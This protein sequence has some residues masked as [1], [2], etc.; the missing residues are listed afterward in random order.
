MKAIAIGQYYPGETPVHRADARLKTTLVIAF[1][2]AIFAIGNF[3]ALVLSA[4]ALALVALNGGLPVRLLVRGLKPLLFIALFALLVNAFLTPGP[5]MAWGFIS[6]SAEGLRIGLLVT[7]RLVL[8]VI[9]TSILTLTSTPVELTDGLE[10]LFSPFQKLRVPVHEIA[11]MMTIALRFVPTLVT[12]A[13][14]IMKAQAARGADF[15]TGNLMRRVRSMVP[16]VIPLFV[17]VFRRADELAVAM[18][19]RCYRGGEGR[20]RM[21][22]LKMKRSDWTTLMLGAIIIIGLVVVGRMGIS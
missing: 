11:M 6:V 19:A 3:T 4:I 15:E 14:Q 10:S 18:E 1:S 13:D 12:E 8:L 7:G 21:R 22:E 2:I 17:G 16:V 9:A 5:R 20:T